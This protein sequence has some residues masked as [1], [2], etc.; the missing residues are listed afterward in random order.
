MDIIGP[1][2]L[3]VHVEVRGA[4]DVYLFAGV[5][6]LR[7]GAEVLFEGTFGFPLDMVTKGWQRAAHRELDERLSTPAQPVH[8]HE[9]AEPLQPREIVRRN[10]FRG[11]FPFGYQR[12]P[13]GTC[14]IHSGGPYD[15]G[16]FFGH[17]SI[18]VR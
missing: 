2:A 17:R 11:T 6:K 14:V 8:T 9:R 4:H 12:S 13:K 15:S 10:P 16:L 1:M 5:R 7:D 3:R 18:D